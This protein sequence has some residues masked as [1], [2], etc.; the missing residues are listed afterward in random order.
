MNSGD[1]ATTVLTK[2]DLTVLH[3]RYIHIALAMC[4]QCACGMH[5]HY[6]LALFNC[7][8]LCVMRLACS[9]HGN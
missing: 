6:K 2:K 1:I 4:I 3:L 5:A 9:V 7:I 8:A